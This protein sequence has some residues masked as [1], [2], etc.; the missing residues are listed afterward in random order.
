VGITV[1][2]LKNGSN[3]FKSKSKRQGW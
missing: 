1:E 3:W 2:F